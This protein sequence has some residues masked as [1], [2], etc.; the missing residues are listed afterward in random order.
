M[1]YARETRLFVELPEPR[2]ALL[3]LS[4][5]RLPLL[6]FHICRIQLG[7]YLMATRFLRLSKAQVTQGQTKTAKL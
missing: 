4:F 7:N 3:R 5:L 6:R 2:S 1:Y